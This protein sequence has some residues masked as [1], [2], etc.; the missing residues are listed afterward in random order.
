MLA[1]LQPA[2]NN[3]GRRRAEAGMGER[4]ANRREGELAKGN[5]GRTAGDRLQGV[6]VYG[7]GQSE[8][9]SLASWT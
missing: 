6:T 8:A 1:A 2:R 4:T 7:P 9:G 5:G 3:P